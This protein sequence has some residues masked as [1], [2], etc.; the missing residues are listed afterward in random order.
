MDKRT[1]ELQLEPVELP[2][3]EEV[4]REYPLLVE[5]LLKEWRAEER[6]LV[7]ALIKDNSDLVRGQIKAYR[8]CRDRI[9]TLRREVL[10]ERNDE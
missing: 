1:E 10:G 2:M 9:M 6:V 7:E 3:L 5:W 8:A 4:L